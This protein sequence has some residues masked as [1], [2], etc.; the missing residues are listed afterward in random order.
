MQKQDWHPSRTVEIVH[1]A[2]IWLA[3]YSSE[4]IAVYILRRGPQ[5]ST[6]F[7]FVA[8][9]VTFLLFLA[10]LRMGN[11]ALVRDVQ[12]ICLY[13]VFV[14]FFGLASR[15]NDYEG[16][17]YAT[18]A[19]AVTVMKIARLSWPMLEHRFG[20]A[21]TWP[22]FGLLGLLRKNEQHPEKIIADGQRLTVYA[23]FPLALLCG[24]LM[25]AAI[26]AFG[27]PINAFI[28]V[29][30]AF[31]GIPV[32]INHLEEREKHHRATQSAKDK[33]EGEAA[34]RAVM[35]AELQAAKAAE[36]KA[37]AATL[38]LLAERDTMMAQLAAH[39][40]RLGD[41]THSIKVALT[42]LRYKTSALVAQANTDELRAAATWLRDELDNIADRLVRLIANAYIEPPAGF[43]P[44]DAISLS[45][46][47]TYFFERFNEVACEHDVNLECNMDGLDSVAVTTDDELVK[48][49]IG[50]LLLNAIKHGQHGDVCLNFTRAGQQVCVSVCNGGPGINDANGANWAENFANLIGKIARQ[51]IDDAKDPVSEALAG[52]SNRVGLRSIDHMA[53]ELGCAIS[54]QSI[55]GHLTTFRFFLPLAA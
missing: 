49:I 22:I 34:A 45:H 23:V 55:P 13:D 41:G 15:I 53:D 11:K 37:H 24:F 43:V 36:E 1:A 2:L 10:T 38:A 54:L 4:A 9:G 46:L 39:N 21:H 20:L 31:W 25:Q 48:N 30:A 5:Q 3:L 17:Y 29:P 26:T 27:V 44:G 52:H 16:V 51:E 12:E 32:L 18:L 8:I 14:Q 50:N 42:P 35:I 40:D 6:G 7:F 28:T 47:C 19:Q 33:A